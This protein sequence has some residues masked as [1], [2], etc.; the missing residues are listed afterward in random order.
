MILILSLLLSFAAPR[1]SAAADCGGILR[2]AETHSNS[3]EWTRESF[4]EMK[5]TES[6]I[7]RLYEAPLTILA[8]PGDLLAMPFR[9]NGVY[10]RASVQGSIADADGRPLADFP[11]KDWP[12]KYQDHRGV[13]AFKGF[14]RSYRRACTASHPCAADETQT[15]QFEFGTD[16]AGSFVFTFE[17]FVVKNGYLEIYF[18]PPLERTFRIVREK[19]G[20]I[21]A[22]EPVSG[23]EI[24]QLAI[25]ESAAS[26]PAK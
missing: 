22:R 10:V 8:A 11:W 12:W 20:N 16:S 19:K 14:V 2:V 15:D 26:P 6:Y 24:C 9:R 3:W 18:G 7:R 5:N 23:E 25:R 1:A 17:G 21:S 4:N 13:K